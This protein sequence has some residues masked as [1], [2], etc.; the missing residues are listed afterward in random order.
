MASSLVAGTVA[1][2]KI[3]SMHLSLSLVLYHYVLPVPIGLP[4]CIAVIAHKL[5]ELFFFIIAV[6]PHKIIVMYDLSV[7]CL[8]D[9][10]LQPSKSKTMVHLL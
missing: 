7:A 2:R 9:K 5:I 1:G 4:S 10:L 6:I 3:F 8:F